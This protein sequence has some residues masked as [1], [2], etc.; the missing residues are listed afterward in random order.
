MLIDFSVENYGPFR[1]KATLSM[2]RTST[3]E[4]PDN[5]ID[6]PAIGEEVL[7]S[8]AVFGPN[9]SGK[10]YI[11][12]AFSALTNMVNSLF[13]I[14][15]KYPWYEPFRLSSKT[16]N[17]PVRMNIR[18]VK[19][20]ILYD[21]SLSFDSNK[22]L[23]ESLYHYPKGHKSKVF[24]RTGQEFEFT[25]AVKHEM[26]PLAKA[27]SKNSTYLAVASRLNNEICIKA[28]QGITQDII[29]VQCDG[30]KLFGPVTRMM[31]ENPVAKEL[32]VKALR[33]SDFGIS[34]IECKLEDREASDSSNDKLI[35]TL[36]KTTPFE[37][38]K[39]V[40]PRVWMKHDLESLDVDEE[41]SLFPIHIESK[42][43][44]QMFY[45]MGPI[46]DALL[47]GKTII[48][49]EFGSYF[50][51]DISRWII[52]QF[53]SD[54]NP[55]GAQ[56]IVNTHDQMLMDTDI[57]FRRDQIL[58]TQK[59]SSDGSSELYSLSDYKGVR[60]DTDIQKNYSIGRYE[61]VPFISP[62]DLIQ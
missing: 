58:F 18:F 61:A 53:K 27:T 32:M 54:S 10:S 17:A 48:I 57:L 51:S 41:A 3:D 8:V 6:S 33:I 2:R 46:I 25:K 30:E 24:V 28:H 42:G 39:V 13:T 1:D 12:H 62:G 35:E 19:D 26:G 40:T 49:D 34:D 9:S 37:K 21:Y 22:V 20:E 11:V 31:S 55:K 16:V 52:S 7:N 29:F 38:Y 15:T 4:H 50:H 45:F 14:D 56:I 43:T 44:R 59:N 23:S 36:K 5:L 47:N 60:K